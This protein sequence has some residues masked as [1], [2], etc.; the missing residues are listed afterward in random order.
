MENQDLKKIA[1]NY[2]SDKIEH[3]YIEIYD[4]VKILKKAIVQ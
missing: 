4:F 2:K 3:G 1:E